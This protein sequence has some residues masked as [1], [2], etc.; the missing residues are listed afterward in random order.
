M[1]RSCEQALAAGVPAVA[2]TDHLDFTIATDGDRIA[3]EHV[4]PR[5]YSRM[6]LLDVPGYL[7]TVQECRQ[8]YPD[9]RILTG[10]E[11]GE[12]HLW[13]ASAADV[14]VRGGFDRIL[15]SVHAMPYDGRLTAADVPVPRDA[16]PRGDAACTSPRWSG[17]SR[18]ATSVRVLAHLDFP[19]RMWPRTAAAYD[20]RAFEPEIRAVLRALAASGRVLEVNTKSPLASAELLRWWREAGGTAVS[21]GSDAHQYWRVG[22]RFKLAVN[23]VEAAGFAPAATASI[24]GGSRRPKAEASPTKSEARGSGG[25]RPPPGNWGARGVWGMASPQ[26]QGGSGGLHPPRRRR[27]RRRRGR[28]SAE[29]GS[30]PPPTALGPRCRQSG[31]S[32]RPSFHRGG[33]SVCPSP[34]H[35][36]RP[37]AGS[38]G[39]GSERRSAALRSRS[40]GRGLRRVPRRGW[41]DQDGRRHLP[42]R[43]D[44]LPRTATGPRPH[45]CWPRPTPRIPLRFTTLPG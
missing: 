16:R 9:L 29:E 24:S 32:C 36:G 43:G 27:V 45:T 19:R 35:P 26:E 14:V 44:R 23:V 22:D 8:R 20:E 30:G 6:H 5:P 11:I 10:A 39:S 33:A 38:T 18:A 7:A 17:W 25:K 28:P 2:F 12:A 41:R 15:G 40:R 1:R 42:G 4:E 31:R 21:F 37:R 34:G 3:A 13:A